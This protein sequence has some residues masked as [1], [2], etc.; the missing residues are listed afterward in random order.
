M[1][2]PKSEA[3]I[4]RRRCE[5]I[6]PRANFAETYRAFRANVDLAELALDP[7]HLFGDMRDET[8]ERAVDHRLVI[9]PISGTPTLADVLS[10]LEPLDE[11]FPTV[12]DPPTK[13]EDLL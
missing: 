2:C 7:E 6:P 12:D 13:P 1:Y 11:D 10:T 3:Q 9:E 5:P 4:S 8:L